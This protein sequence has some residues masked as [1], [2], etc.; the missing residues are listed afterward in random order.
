MKKKSR[1]YSNSSVL[2]AFRD[3]HFD[4]NYNNYDNS[5]KNNVISFKI[6]FR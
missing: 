1:V 6:V 3:L 4:Q 2:N 5:N